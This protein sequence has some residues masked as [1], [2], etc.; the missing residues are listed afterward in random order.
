LRIWLGAITRNQNTSEGAMFVT[1]N[2][3]RLFF[4]VLNPALELFP[5]G[6][7]EKPV[8]LCLHG[9]PGGDHQSMRPAFDRLSNVAQVVYLDQR[10]GGRSDHGPQDGWR[11]DQW[12]DDIAGVCDAL[13]VEPIILGQSGGAIFTQAFLARHPKRAKGAILLNACARMDRGDLIANWETIGGPEAAA[14]ARTMYTAPTPEVMPAFFQHCLPHY[15]R[16][17]A[18]LDPSMGARMTFNFA[19]T[20]RFFA[21]GGEAWRFDH[22]GKLGEVA[23]PVLVCIGA[24]DP[25]TRPNWGRE[26]YDSLPPDK[27]ELVVFEDSSHSVHTDEPD[28]FFGAMEK[29]ISAIA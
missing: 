6:L 23:C 3:V 28:A 1:V 13:G 15:S 25:I 5:G 7:K 19:I 20:N 29:F 10:G 16:R 17:Q 24:H 22:R 11:L 12:A 27:R 21:E 8:L 26:V 18:P 14:A 9:G 2:G 4:D